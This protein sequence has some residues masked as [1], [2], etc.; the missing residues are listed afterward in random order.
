MGEVV[1]HPVCR[2]LFRQ[3]SLETRLT[4]SLPSDSDDSEDDLPRIVDVIVKTPV[5]PKEEEDKRLETVPECGSVPAV[6]ETDPKDFDGDGASVP[7]V[8]KTD[9]KDLDG[10]GGSASE[11]EKET[12][13]ECFIDT[14]RCKISTEDDFFTAEM[15]SS[16][17]T[18]NSVSVGTM[19]VI[20]FKT[21]KMAS[22]RPKS[23]RPPV[24][25]KKDDKEESFW[26]KIGTLGRK[27]RIKEVQEVQQEGKYAIDSPG[28]PTAPDLP[29]EEYDLEENEERSMIEP[30]SFEDPKLKELIIVLIEW[31]N[32]ELADQRIIVKDIDEDLYDGQ[33]LQKLLEKLTREKLDVPE[34]TQSEDGQKQKLGIVLRA[35]NRVLGPQRWSQQKWSVES[36]HS[37]NVVAILHLLVA[38]ARHFRAPVRLPE[39]VAVGVVVVQKHG[40]SLSHRTVLEE[41]TSTYDDLGMRCER[42]AFDTLFDHAPDK[43]QVVKKS[44]VTFVNKHLNKVNLEVTDLD[45]QFHDG[46]YLTLLMGLLEGFFVPLYSFHLTPQDFEQKVHNVG[47]AFDLMQDVGLAKPKARPEDIVNLDL[48]STLRVLYNLFTKYKNI[49]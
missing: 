32:D 46:V 13:D 26:D 3:S 40:G 38:L 15:A 39:N 5:A 41:I 17:T 10:D 47:F 14:S 23:P 6:V 48:K 28:S 16:A 1:E 22:P 31:I 7:S 4:P 8:V 49:S 12:E 27:K 44:L 36:V 30:R 33:V 45:N 43:L 42:D 21:A 24:S 19:K 9:P 20:G 35:A 29:P 18:K 2:T 25:A 34:V 11:H 37:K